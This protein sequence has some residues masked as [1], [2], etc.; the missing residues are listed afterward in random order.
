MITMI[1]IA[2]KNNFGKKCNRI[3]VIMI[4]NSK[5]QNIRKV[6]FVLIHPLEAIT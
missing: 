5:I 6:A 3:V 2:L 1:K 4:V